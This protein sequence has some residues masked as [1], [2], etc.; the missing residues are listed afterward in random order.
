MD[1][2][3]TKLAD[4]AVQLPSD[5]QHTVRKDRTW[6][7]NVPIFDPE[8]SLPGRLQTQLTKDLGGPD[9]AEAWD[10]QT[11]T[12]DDDVLDGAVFGVLNL[13]AGWFYD[14]KKG[15]GLHPDP[16]EHRKDPRIRVLVAI[17]R[18]CATRIGLVLSKAF[19]LNVNHERR[20][21]T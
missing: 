16:K 4:N 21:Q 12:P 15:V 9:C 19:A 13:D 18:R 3:Q 1:N 7:L 8:A 10:A 11:D 2:L 20:T 14:H 17:M 6:L 5:K